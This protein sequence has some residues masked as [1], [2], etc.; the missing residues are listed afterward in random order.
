ML[1]PLAIFACLT[2]VAFAAPEPAWS[3]PEFQAHFLGSY[4]FDGP[5][6]PS[7]TP[8]E[9][10]VLRGLLPLME[11]GQYQQA[12]R[13]L[14]AA[15]T[16]DSSPALDFTLGN[17][18]RQAGEATLAENAY[19]AALKKMPGFV[20]AS[21]NL[22]MM[23][24]QEGRYRE[25]APLISEAITRGDNAAATQGALAY[26]HF[27]TDDFSSA[28]QGYEQA[29]FL[30]PESARWQLGRAQC[31]LQL[32]RAAEALQVAERYLLTHPDNAEARRVAVNASIALSD[33]ERAV[34][35]LELL[36]R[37]GQINAEV[38]IQLGR[39]YLVLGLPQHARDAWIEALRQ[40]QLPPVEQLL[41]AAEQLAAQGQRADAEALLQVVYEK[42]GQALSGEAMN[43]LL[44]LQGRLKQDAGDLAAAAILLNQA[45]KRDPLDGQA[46]LFLGQVEFAQ[47]NLAEAQIALERAAAM[48]GVSADACLELARLHVQQQ[49]WD[50]AIEALR[51]A[52]AI[53]PEDRVARYMESIQRVAAR[54]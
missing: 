3:S 44:R 15:L 45:A 38:L 10:Q 42:F 6:E 35:H 32:D 23:L 33:W 46:Q 24:S 18:Y 16:A 51:R 8:A 50:A 17:L 54:E 12:A 7:V 20:R 25:A 28:L 49:Q 52:Q 13:Q 37:Q 31:L 40:E 26:C 14:S 41:T 47:G 1:R 34:A 48:E 39:A 4:G 19:R 29:A 27:Q 11:T 53:R 43:Q 21:R 5:R 22:G 36:R 9:Q 2:S 30:E